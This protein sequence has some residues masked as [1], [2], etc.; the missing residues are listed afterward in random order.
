[1]KIL[2]AVCFLLIVS[3]NV[4]A[5]NSAGIQKDFDETFNNYYTAAVKFINGLGLQ[6]ENR[7]NKFVQTHELFITQLRSIS[8]IQNV[9][10]DSNNQKVIADGIDLLEKLIAGYRKALNKQI[11]EVE[12]NKY[13]NALKT[14][15]LNQ[16]QNLINSLKSE[17]QRVP[18]VGQCW[19]AVRDELGVIVKKGFLAARNASLT[20]LANADITLNMNELIVKATVD[21]NALFI[22][23]CQIPNVNVNSCISTFLTTAQVTIPM[24]VNTWASS[25]ESALKVHLQLAEILINSAISSAVS[26]VVPIIN[27]TL[28]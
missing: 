1:M 3:S 21:S 27:S 12:F 2:F 15:Y 13:M 25:N 8:N 9:T 22:S 4:S 6:L 10:L 14:N 28:R 16:A 19:T 23:S 24:N 26:D 17:V 20:T 7:I 5:Q 18:A 11:F